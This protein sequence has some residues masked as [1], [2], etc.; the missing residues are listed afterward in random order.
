MLREE[1]KP[2]VR[3]R[4][5]GDLARYVSEEDLIVRDESDEQPAAAVVESMN[6]VFME[7]AS[8]EREHQAA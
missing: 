3:I 6:V 5:C 8:V 2:A 7:T 4:V 1:N